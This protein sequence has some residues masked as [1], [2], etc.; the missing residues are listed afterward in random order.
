M[1]KQALAAVLLCAPAAVFAWQNTM[2]G[3]GVTE[4]GLQA[5]LERVTRQKG[6]GL[7]MPVLGQKQLAAAMALGV[8]DQAALM[9]QLATAAKAIVMAPAFVAAHDAWIAKEYNA[10]DHGLK[11]TLTSDKPITTEAQADA[12]TKDLQRQAAAVYVQMTADAKIADLKMMFDESLKDW[13]TDAARAKGADKAKAAKL[14]SRAEAIKD[15]STTA[16]DKFRRGY[17]VLLSTAADGPDTE[18]G[19][20]GASAST[21][22]EAEQAAWDKYNLRGAVKRVLTQAIAEAPSVDYAAQTT[23][24]SSTRVFVNPAYEKKSPIWKAMYRAGKAPTAAGLE[25]A[26]AWLKEL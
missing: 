9:K 22:D 25:I 17:A 13:T 6:D 7:S 10:I 24:K 20:F 3:V 12:F 1:K 8:A 18:A 16:P 21:K 14:V 4:A 15:L 5:Q 19:V 11:L 23:M 2:A 26:R